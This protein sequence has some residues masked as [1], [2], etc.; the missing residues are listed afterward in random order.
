VSAHPVRFTFEGL[1]VEPRLLIVDDKDDVRAAMGE[2]MRRCGYACETASSAEDALIMLNST[3]FDV[4]ISDI[5]LTGMGGLELTQV[6]R[7][8]YQS[9]VIVMT[10]YSSD[11]SYEEAVRLGASD[12]IIKPFRTEELLLR[13]RRVLRER[14]LTEE[15]NRMMEKLQKLAVT[16]GLTT[17][18]NSRHFYTLL[19]L[20]V[21]RSNRYKHPLS[22]LLIDID[23]FKN[24]NDSF[25]HL[26]GDKVL[27]RFSQ[28]LK[29]CL[30][31]NDSAFRYG[32][33]EFTVTLPET[34][35]DEA[36]TVAQRIRAALEAEVFTPPPGR[37]A[38][39]TISI[40]V[41]E[42]EPL[43]D[44]TTFIRR[45]DEAMYLSKQTGRNRVS[46][47]F[48]GSPRITQSST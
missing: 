37:P 36:R 33:E 18:F 15:R 14:E 22:L 38:Y 27:V 26:E 47:L 45:A 40:G 16:D 19:E 48:A 23:H 9:D 21:D 39:V 1:I 41:T 34:S 32:G 42:Y 10:G 46:L 17:L 28:L 7:R 29:S 20:E 31:T 2:Y 8:D 25:G 44:M 6:I 30:R 35:A 3:A 12:F 5:Q 4:V 11:Y 24:Y 43:E 13:V